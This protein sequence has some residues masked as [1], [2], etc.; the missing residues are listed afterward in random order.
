[1]SDEIHQPTNSQQPS[2][3]KQP[4][5][6]AYTVT[7]GDT[8]RWTPIGAAWHIKNGQKIVLN[9]LPTNGEVILQ[10]SESIKQRRQQQVQN[11]PLKP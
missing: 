4:D 3:S 8:P 6:I 5:F 2:Q 9:A 1:M 11:Q 7:K 10:S